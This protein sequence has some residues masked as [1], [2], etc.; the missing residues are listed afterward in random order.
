MKNSTIITLIVVGIALL[1]GMWW[2]YGQWKIQRDMIRR[3]QEVSINDCVKPGQP[4]IANGVRWGCTNDKRT[5]LQVNW[6]PNL[7]TEPQVLAAETAK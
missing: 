4:V 2:V 6:I 5:Y 3:G 7:Q 1:C